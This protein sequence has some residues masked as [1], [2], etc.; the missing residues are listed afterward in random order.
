MCWSLFCYAL[1]CAQSSFA[2]HLK[3][4][5][6]TGCLAIIVLQ[7]YCCYNCFMALP[8]SAVGRSAQCDCGI[9]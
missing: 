7:M 2:N 3:E 8:H 9:S 1:L 5:V 4:E 6:K